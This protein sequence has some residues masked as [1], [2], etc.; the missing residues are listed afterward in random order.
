MSTPIN[1]FKLGLFT[2]FGFLILIGGLFAF[3]MRSYF[4]STSV[5]ETYIPGDVSGLSVG[6]AVELKGV[7]VGKVTRIDFSWNKYKYTE[8]GPAYVVVEFEVKDNIS[9]VARDKVD[10]ER[11]QREIQRGFRA[12]LKEQGITG[13]SLLS[14]DY[15]DPALNPPMPFSWQPEHPYIPAAPGQFVSLLASV[16]RN[17]KNLEKL[18]LPAINQ[19]LQHDLKSAGQM[20]DNMNGT[21]IKLQPRIESIDVDA[22]NQVLTN[23][24]RT[25]RNLDETVSELKRYPAGFLLGN[26]PPPVKEAQPPAK[27]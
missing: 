4:E 5:F 13:T 12:R 25:M 10:N 26:P 20:L 8:G 23:A 2:L 6:A 24:Q 9:P 15:L 17:L 27:K 22:L 11:I 1:H 7:R 21:I 16:E 14:L 19:L 3:G 18:D